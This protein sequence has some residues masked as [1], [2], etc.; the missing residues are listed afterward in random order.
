[1]NNRSHYLPRVSALERMGE[2]ERAQVLDYHLRKLEEEID[3]LKSGYIYVTDGKGCA[4]HLRLAHARM[5][6]LIAVAQSCGVCFE[7]KEAA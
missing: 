3:S 2:Y 7:E 6:R 5:R 4:H 1:M